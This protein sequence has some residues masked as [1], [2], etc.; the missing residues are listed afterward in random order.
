MF[1]KTEF[2]N[3]IIHDFKNLY[4][5]IHNQISFQAVTV[6]F[7]PGLDL[8][9]HLDEFFFNIIYFALINGF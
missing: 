2:D 5:G 1:K 4:S 6:L 9:D 8:P 7:S 3:S